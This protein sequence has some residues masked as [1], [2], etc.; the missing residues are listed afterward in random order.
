MAFWPLVDTR[1]EPRAG[2]FTACL[3][4]LR[5][6]LISSRS[7]YREYF[8]FRTG[9]FSGQSVSRS[10]QPQYGRRTLSRYEA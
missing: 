6:T 9:L 5:P 7:S 4:S 1:D 3:S 8:C 10:A 2:S